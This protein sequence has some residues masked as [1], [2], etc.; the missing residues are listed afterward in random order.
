MDEG[1]AY[2]QAAYA[3]SVILSRAVADG[4]PLTYARIVGK[5]QRDEP[6][7]TV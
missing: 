5:L 2:A 3:R 6:L 4:N 7:I 1:Q